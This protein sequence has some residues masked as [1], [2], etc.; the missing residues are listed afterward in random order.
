[1][2]EERIEIGTEVY[3]TEDPSLRG[4]LVRYEDDCLGV[5]RTERRD[6][7][8]PIGEIAP[9]EEDGDDP[10]DGPLNPNAGPSR[11][12]GDEITDEQWAARGSRLVAFV[13]PRCG[14]SRPD[15][16]TM[17]DDQR[18]HCH[19]CGVKF[20]VVRI[21]PPSTTPNAER[22]RLLEGIARSALDIPTLKTRN[23]DSLDFHATAV[24][25]LK[26][27]LRLAYAAGYEHAVSERERRVAPQS[28]CPNCCEDDHDL[29]VWDEEGESITCQ[30]C[31]TNYKVSATT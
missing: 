3:C 17:A 6:E 14:E 26:R 8:V 22:D 25:R 10:G 27:A 1:M 11:A 15:R 19:S 23:S 29:L 16:L 21:G 24:W 5:I 28:S 13:C 31:R 12:N 20:D 2:T 9:V 4:T 30:R 18:V 7:F